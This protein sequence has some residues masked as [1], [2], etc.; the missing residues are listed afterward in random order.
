MRGHLKIFFGYAAG[1]GKTY[2]MLKAAHMAKRRHMDV[3]AGLIEP[4]SR[5]QTEALQK[6]LELLPTLHVEYNGM[7][8]REFDLD[9]AIQRNP[10]IILI[11]ELAHT[12]VSGCRHNKRYQDVL[13]LLKAGIDVYTTV[14]VQ[15]IESLNDMV[16]S[17][18]G[19]MVQER[20]PDFV[21]DDADQVELVDIEPQELIERLHTGMIYQKSLASFTSK[22]LFTE[23]KLTA[24]REIALRRCA[25]RVNKLIETTRMKGNSDYHT[26]EHIMVCLSSS[27]SNAKII[28]TA[29]RMANAFRGDFTA[30]F[31]Q[32][33]NYEVMDDHDKKRLRA[34][35]HLAQQ[36]GA[37]IETVYGDDIS[38]QIA[39]FVRLSGVSKVVIGRSSA[40]RKHW[41]G[42][43]TLTEQL[44]ANV[45]N[46][47]V[48][49]I[50]DQAAGIA[51]YRKKRKQTVFS[52]AD[53]LKCIAILTGASCLGYLFEW[54]GFE[55]A[56]IITL[57]VLAVLI[58]SVVTANRAY[59]LIA[60]I[61]SVLV[62]N[63]LFTEPK[64]TL[65]A[66]DSEYPVTF[67]IMFSAALL[68]GTLATRLKSAAKQ[69][70]RAAFRTKILFDTN[71]MLHQAKNK[72][73]I[74]SGTAQ[75]LVKLLNRDIVVYFAEEDSLKSALVFPAQEDTCTKEYLTEE[76][77]RV[78]QWALRNN[79]HAGATTNTL[80]NAKCLY[81]AIRVNDAVYGVVGIAIGEDS[82]DTFENSILL[83]ILGECGLALE[84][85]KNAREK[86]EAAILAKNE[87]LRANL[88]R[89]ISHDLRTPLTSISGNA[90]NL[91]SNGESFDA[92]TKKHLYQ[93]IYDDSMWLINLVENLLSVTRLVEGRLNLHLTAELVDEVVK[94]ALRH[95][96]R[97]KT[98]HQITVEHQDDLLLA[99]M[100]ARLIV[101]VI[102]NLVDNAIKYTP[103]GSHIYI[104][105]QKEKKWAVISIS[106]D[107]E[108]IPDENKERVFEMFYSGA[109]MVVDSRRSLGLGLALCKSIVNAHGGTITVSDNLPHGTV[110]TFTLPVEEVQ[111][112]E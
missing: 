18:T 37:E 110:F 41:F 2:A 8:L 58:T 77:K 15:H 67:L 61:I 86:E 78:A 9:A 48:H 60:S 54:Y 32:T 83:S 30:L 105:T 59:S 20:I 102:I 55:E 22:N 95:V 56:N 101:Q 106:D 21:F 68:I 96:N 87:Q 19:V 89:A 104:K 5:P 66:Y 94:E 109:N 46:L 49:I 63:F 52:M 33:S 92:E 4:H 74:I 53:T 50:P 79:E 107:G 31:V 47:D 99:K 27:P 90:S 76:E 11:D 43:P 36:L 10:Q 81:L 97:L 44:I 39:E 69:S 73:E 26:D 7:Q 29:A 100:D 13:E 98:E 80:S 88:L 1:V 42:K 84:N 40:A 51:A 70:A 45:P 38:F 85:E 75:Q 91:L 64:Y 62:F 111:L 17:V 25:D 24:L 71:Q 28:R 82:L 34:N 108:G 57:Y 16:A 65:R 103:K 112:H 12:N 14:N 23:E 72:E 3:V 35:M 93:D 6:G